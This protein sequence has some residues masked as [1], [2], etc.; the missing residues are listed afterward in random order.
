MGVGTFPYFSCHVLQGALLKGRVFTGNSVILN[1]HAENSLLSG[2]ALRKKSSCE[3]ISEE[4]QAG[5]RLHL[6]NC[7]EPI[8]LQ[9]ATTLMPFENML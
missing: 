8:F 9:M 5:V 4:L 2:K 6:P 1:L 3:P 7:G